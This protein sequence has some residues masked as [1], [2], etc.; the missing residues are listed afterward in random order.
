MT[1]DYVEMLRDHIKE[2]ISTM[3]TGEETDCEGL[4]APEVWTPVP[5]P[6]R[7]HAFGIPVAR[8]VAEQKVPLV[9]ER[10]NSKRHN[11]YRRIK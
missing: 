9:F 1:D 4:I 3:E 8:I 2:A 7:R 5:P 10:L 6:E 11:I